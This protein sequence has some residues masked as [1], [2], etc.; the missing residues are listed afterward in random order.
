MI[1]TRILIVDDYPENI[2]ALSELIRSDDVEIFQAP[3]GEAALSVFS[4]TDIDLALFDVQ[5]PI[6]T[7]FEL[8]RLVR[9]VRQYRHLPII[10][11]TAQQ[12][13]AA[14]IFEGYDT[15]AVDLLFK[16]LDPHVVRSK[17]RAFVE[18]SQQRMR[19]KAHVDELEKLKHQAE[20]ANVAKTQFL[21]NM[22]HEIRT[23]LASVMGFAEIL[24]QEGISIEEKARSADAVKRNGRLLMRLIDDILDLSKIEAGKLEFERTPFD[25]NELIKDVEASLSFRA[26]EK[27][28]SLHFRR[29]GETKAHYVS[30]TVR[31]KQVF[32]NVIGNAVKFTHR[33]EVTVELDIRG[34]DLTQAIGANFDWIT[35]RVTDQGI[36]LSSEHSRRL[37]Q[38]FGQADASTSR[39]F[40]GSGLG[41]VISREIAR[42]LGGGLELVSSEEGKGSTFQVKLLLEKVPSLSKG[43]EAEPSIDM[44]KTAAP[45]DLSAK[46][47]MVVDDSPDNLT[48]IELFLQDTKAQMTFAK[49]GYEAL[50]LLMEKK[51]DLVLMDIQMPGKD[52]HET[53]E[54]MRQLGFRK[55][56]IALTAHATKSEQVKCIA[57]GCDA[58][59]VKPIDRKKLVQLIMSELQGS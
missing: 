5:M 15:G 43:A 16:P 6:M 4:E 33:G 51:F 41:L 53:T 14:V 59:M 31:I 42:A 44:T 19:L 32:L 11:V 17:V 46:N 36:G 24:S 35:L 47:I 2:T 40:G 55:P 56:I 48:L 20:S 3:S 45:A 1:R 12:Q 23:P 34:K 57:S 22:S 7:G 52:G 9:G 21:A 27:G 30:D 13:G 38:P 18:I 29:T 8:A 58:V 54:E 28:V 25:L 39:N 49:N 26:K 50:D 37:F 10:F